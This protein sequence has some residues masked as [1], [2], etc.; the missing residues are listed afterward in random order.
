[1]KKKMFGKVLGKAIAFVTIIGF[2]MTACVDPNDGD[3]D[4]GED[5]GDGGKNTHVRFVMDISEISDEWDCVFNGEDESS[6]VFLKLNDSGIPT[7]LYVKPE[8]DSDKGVTWLFKDN[9]LPDKAVCNG[10]VF[11]F[12]NFRGYTFDYAVIHPNNED[13]NEIEYYRDNETDVNWDT[14]SISSGPGRENLSQARFFNFFKPHA[15]TLENVLDCVGTSLGIVSCVTA[16]TNP[17]SAIGCGVFIGSNFVSEVVK[18]GFGDSVQN[19]VGQTAINMFGCAT[20]VAGVIGGGNLV[21]L[22]DC[23]SAAIGVV[24]TVSK[25]DQNIAKNKVAITGLTLNASAL[26]LN[27]GDSDLYLS[28]VG[29]VPENAD[30]TH[31]IRTFIS[32]NPDI[33]KVEGALVTALAPGTAVITVTTKPSG[34]SAT[35]T[36]TVAGA[37]VVVPSGTFEVKNITDLKK[38]GSG[39]DGWT[40]SASYMQTANINLS[41]EADWTPIGTEAKPFTGRYDGSG[42]TISNLT[43]SSNTDNKGLFGYTSGSAVV[44]NVGIINCNI[45]IS[46]A[47]NVGGVAGYNGGMVQG[48]YVTG[49]IKGKENVGGIVGYNNSTVKNCYATATVNAQQQVGGIVGYNNSTVENCY[50]TGAVTGTGTPLNKGGVAGGAPNN[51]VKNCVALN[52][53]VTSGGGNAGR[54]VGNNSTLSNSYGRKDM[55]I[56]GSTVTSNSAT[57]KDGSDITSTNWSASTWW[58]GTAKFDAAVWDFSGISETNLPTLKGFSGA[59]NPVIQ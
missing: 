19:E 14:F 55:K 1:M 22:V 31:E 13:E 50:A 24:S 18:I 53:S 54:V 44:Q 27:V 42:R 28:P 59:Q 7:C 2:L 46:G 26:R 38:V 25:I 37:A 52:P 47:Y 15:F 48:C 36:V 5:G 23:G 6:L 35:C 57:S 12:S 21:D 3:G 17:A 43:I 20:G 29:V 8:K 58:T 33:V 41:S 10:V 16:F 45:N 51:T 11:Q 40:L 30:Q 39:T 32:S 49:I 34:Y 4:G 9:G 56:N